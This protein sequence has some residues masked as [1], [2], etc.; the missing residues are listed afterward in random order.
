MWINGKAQAQHG[1]NDDLVMALA[2]VLYLRDTALRM[3][4]AGIELTK[5][6]LQNTHK[7]VY[8]PVNNNLVGKFKLPG[9][10]GYES[11]DW[12]K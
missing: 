3:R 1:Y 12:L 9:G 7:S 2:M 8:K 6:S 5:K 4:Q 11:L 10:R